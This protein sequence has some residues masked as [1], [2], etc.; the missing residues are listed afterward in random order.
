MDILLILLPI[1]VIFLM[2]VAEKRVPPEDDRYESLMRRSLERA[3]EINE[4]ETARAETRRRSTA[5]SGFSLDTGYTPSENYG[6]SLIDTSVSMDYDSGSSS[7]CGGGY[8]S[9]SS[10]GGGSCGGSS[11]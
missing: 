5:R 9:G 2:W 4:R 6:V 1:T 7:D 11:D 8:D 10:D 3:R